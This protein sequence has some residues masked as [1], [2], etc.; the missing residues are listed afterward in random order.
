MR[1]PLVPGLHVATTAVVDDPPRTI[2]D[3][4]N[5]FV[6]VETGTSMSWRELYLCDIQSDNNVYSAK[7]LSTHI[8]S[9]LHRTHK[10]T[11]Y[12]ET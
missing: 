4:S 3:I 2:V 7:H 5:H 12:V 10:F 11:S 9:E 6:R 1:L 8:L